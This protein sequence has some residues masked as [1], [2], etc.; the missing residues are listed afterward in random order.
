MS[1]LSSLIKHN[2]TIAPIVLAV[3]SAGI[4]LVAAPLIAPAIASALGGEA[5]AAAAISAP[6]A[7]AAA[8][9]A[10]SRAAPASRRRLAYR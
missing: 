7:A 1:W 2:K 10:P 3:V 4:G 6:T 9:A 5:A 8:D